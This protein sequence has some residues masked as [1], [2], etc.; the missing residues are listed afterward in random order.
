MFTPPD[1]LYAARKVAT[2]RRA[3]EVAGFPLSQDDCRKLVA[4]VWGYVD[5][6]EVSAAVDR[7]E[8]P[9]PFDEDLAGHDF[10][11]SRNHSGAM[12]VARRRGKLGTIFCEMTRL[13][14]SLG[15]SFLSS[16]RLS[17][18]PERSGAFGIVDGLV[19]GKW[20][21]PNEFEAMRREASEPLPPIWGGFIRSVEGT[22]RP[23]PSAPLLPVHRPRR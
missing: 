6:A 15:D 5:W 22:L 17:D 2:V 10:L 20:L 9:G 14:P 19:G 23:P 11:T 4:R 18:D 8:A 1:A 3:C 12:R 13:P 16:V 21:S 7:E